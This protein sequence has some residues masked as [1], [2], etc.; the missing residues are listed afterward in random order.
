MNIKLFR[1]IDPN[2][3]SDILGGEVSE[4]NAHLTIC[5][6]QSAKNHRMLNAGESMIAYFSCSGTYGYYRVQ[7]TK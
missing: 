7:R 6:S 5:M 2:N 4:D 1:I 3:D